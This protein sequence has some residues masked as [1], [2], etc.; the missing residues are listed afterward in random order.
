MNNNKGQYLGQC[1]KLMARPKGQ[2]PHPFR[3]GLWPLRVER[4]KPTYAET[5]AKYRTGF[6]DGF[7]EAIRVLVKLKQ[8][9]FIRPQ[10]IANILGEHYSEALIPWR[11]IAVAASWERPDEEPNKTLP[12]SIKIEDWPSI[13]DQV[14]K[15]DGRKCASCGSVEDLQVDH[16]TPVFD[17]GLPFMSNLRVLCRRCNLERNKET[18]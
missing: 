15:R 8:A 7:G 13:R 16:V 10:E 2:G 12:P 1:P 6:V 3:G 4:P 5:E 14:F 9:G 18:E 17:G 11:K